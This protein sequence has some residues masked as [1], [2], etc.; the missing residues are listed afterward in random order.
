VVRS[1]ALTNTVDA[2]TPEATVSPTGEGSAMASTSSNP[3]V[4]FWQQNGWFRWAVYALGA[5][6]LLFGLVP[7]ILR[8]LSGGRR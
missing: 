5:V 6:I 3:F 4:R 8:L 2:L 7:F 1:S